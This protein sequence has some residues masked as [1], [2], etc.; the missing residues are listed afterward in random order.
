MS[1]GDC[2]VLT[3][4]VPGLSHWF[5]LK[6]RTRSEPAAQTALRNLGYEA[7]SPTYLERRRYSDRI[8]AVQTPVFP[9]Y[10]FCRLD[11]QRKLPVISAPAVEYIVSFGNEPMPVPEKQ[12]EAIRSVVAAGGTPTE[13]LSIG[14]RVRIEYGSL[15]GV[16]GI[17]VRRTGS[18]RLVVSIELLRR[19]VTLEINEDQV[20]PA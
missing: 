9:G 8:K 6:V 7:F 14:Q 2:F 12:I 16:E 15:A 11:P 20:S 1:I 19:S 4:D 5:A 13:Y 18:T 17:L 3:A 10:I